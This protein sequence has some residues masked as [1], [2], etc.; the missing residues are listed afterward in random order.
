MPRIEEM[1]RLLRETDLTT[2]A[3]TRRVR[4]VSRDHAAEFTRILIEIEI[5]RVV[6]NRMRQSRGAEREEFVHA[7]SRPVAQELAAPVAELLGE[8][9]AEQ[10]AIRSRW[11]QDAIPPWRPVLPRLVCE[12][13]V[14]NLDAWAVPCGDRSL[15]S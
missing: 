14:S 10:P 8:A 11:Q 7:V 3:V 9:S 6:P 5:A 12:V 13:R 4:W 1:A 15:A 2:E